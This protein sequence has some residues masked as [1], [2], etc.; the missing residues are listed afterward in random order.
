MFLVPPVHAYFVQ[1]RG[2]ETVVL[3]RERDRAI[4]SGELAATGSAGYPF[5]RAVA[6]TFRSIAGPVPFLIL[7]CE[8]EPIASVANGG[9]RDSSFSRWFPDPW[10]SK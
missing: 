9:L 1:C 4:I 10:D 6:A 5:P 3:S 8:P 7:L 2:Y